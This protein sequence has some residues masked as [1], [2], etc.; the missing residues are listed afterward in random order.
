MQNLNLSKEPLYK[1]NLTKSNSSYT[2]KS[3]FNNSN[4]NNLDDTEKS[5]LIN[6]D[7]SNLTYS[8]LSNIEGY[9][10]I[11]NNSLNTICNKSYSCC[12]E[13]RP[14]SNKSNSIGNKAH[15]TAIQGCLT[16]SLSQSKSQSRS[17]ATDRDCVERALS[18][19]QEIH[20][21]TL[22]SKTV[23]HE[24]SLH[25]SN[26]GQECSLTFKKRIS[27]SSSDNLVY[28]VK[29]LQREYSDDLEKILMRVS[30]K[31]PDIKRIETENNPDGEVILKFFKE[32]FNEP[33]LL[34]E[35]SL[36]TIKLLTYLLVLYDP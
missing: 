33:F 18:L 8:D 22:S 30:A 10:S 24:S 23:N 14:I 34:D 36:G 35:L 3:D 20:E 13:P 6:T 15:S 1:E 26:C 16:Q 31:L 2:K 7:L 25:S 19:N 27:S 32:C 21:S 28:M 4:Q 11:N 9:F 5:K 29:Y 12:N 17:P